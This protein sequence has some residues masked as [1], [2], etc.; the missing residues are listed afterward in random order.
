MNDNR[1][2]RQYTPDRTH[3]YRIDADG[4]PP[5][6]AYPYLEMQHLPASDQL[7]IFD[8]GDFMKTKRPDDSLTV[9]RWSYKD[10][11][12]DR[13]ESR[14]IDLFERHLPGTADRRGA[15]RPGSFADGSRRM[16]RSEPAPR[17]LAA[18]VRRGL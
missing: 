3:E 6:P 2:L 17:R 5:W 1:S 14:I 10:K 12:V 16:D 13:N 11:K 7:A 8:Q 4:E 18:Q 15:E 9:V